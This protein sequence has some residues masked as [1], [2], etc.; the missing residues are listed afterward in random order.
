MKIVFFFTLW[1]ECINIFARCLTLVYPSWKSKTYILTYQM[2]LLA[3]IYVCMLFLFKVDHIT[4]KTVFRTTFFFL[5]TEIDGQFYIFQSVPEL[6][7]SN[8]ST[9]SLSNLSLS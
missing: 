8:L 2:Y 9:F 1:I 7:M 6:D 3:I 4:F 5:L